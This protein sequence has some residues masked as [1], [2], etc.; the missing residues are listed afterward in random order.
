MDWTER[1]RLEGALLV[2]TNPVES[3]TDR[4]LVVESVQEGPLFVPKAAG[5]TFAEAPGFHR[6]WIAEAAVHIPMKTPLCQERC[7]AEAPAL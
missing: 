6:E 5:A 3:R 2:K 4:T 1:Q 7:F